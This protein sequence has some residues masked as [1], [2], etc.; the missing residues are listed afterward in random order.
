MTGSKAVCIT[1]INAMKPTNITVD[2]NTTAINQT[3]IFFLFWSGLGME[4]T[5]CTKNIEA[6]VAFCDLC[7]YCFLNLIIKQFKL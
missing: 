1:P 4:I 2:A 3:G 5:A 6:L 7:L